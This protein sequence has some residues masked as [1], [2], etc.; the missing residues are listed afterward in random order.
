MF[1]AVTVAAGGSA[2]GAGQ[3][4]LGGSGAALAHAIAVPGGGVSRVVLVWRKLDGAG[5]GAD[6]ALSKVA[7]SSRR[8]AQAG[9]RADGVEA[10]GS[11]ITS[12][13]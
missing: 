7:A 13:A 8:R 4:V 12:R 5:A 6:H 3:A 9:Q 1:G 2:C 11:A 10:L